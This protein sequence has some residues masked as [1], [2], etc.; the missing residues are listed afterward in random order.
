MREMLV[1]TD[2]ESMDLKIEPTP[3][4]VHARITKFRASAKAFAERLAPNVEISWRLGR[5]GRG[6]RKT[7]AA[8]DELRLYSSTFVKDK[9][10]LEAVMESKEKSPNPPKHPAGAA[11]RR[12]R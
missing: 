9:D 6:V 1:A 12:G 10:L 4:M 3:K 7:L 5:C 11:R 8:P 2:I